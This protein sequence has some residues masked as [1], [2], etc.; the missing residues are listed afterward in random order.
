MNTYCRNSS[1]N[2]SKLLF[3]FSWALEAF[4]AA[5]SFLDTL[6]DCGTIFAISIIFSAGFSSCLVWGLY[7]F[8]F[9]RLSSSVVVNLKIQFKL[10]SQHNVDLVLTSRARIISSGFNPYFWD[11]WRRLLKCFHKFFKNLQN[12]HTKISNLT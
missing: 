1:L 10:Y 9:S 7:N 2:N 6:S 3:F 5:L 4:F 8:P 11:R 12:S